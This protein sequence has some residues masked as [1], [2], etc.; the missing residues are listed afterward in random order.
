MATFAQGG[1]RRRVM[2]STT[3]R[4][5]QWTSPRSKSPENAKV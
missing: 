3:M 5:I 2:A 1:T 4:I